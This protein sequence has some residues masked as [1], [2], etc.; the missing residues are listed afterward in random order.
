[1]NSNIQ[2]ILPCSHGYCSKCID[3]W[4]KRNDDCPNCRQKIGLNNDQWQLTGT[5][6]ISQEEYLTL[7][8][9][10]IKQIMQIIDWVF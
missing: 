5:F 4:H 8:D 10:T 2:V 6:T 7:K 3:D 1:M 9:S